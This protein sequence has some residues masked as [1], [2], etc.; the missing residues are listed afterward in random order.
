MKARDAIVMCLLALVP[1]QGAHAADYAP[2]EKLTLFHCGRCH[3][4]NQRNRYG[5]IGSTPS[6]AA[7]RTLADWEARFKTFWTLAPHPAFTQVA[8]M[9]EPFPADRPPPIHPVEL[10]LEQVDRIIG[11][12][13]TIAPKD[14]GAPI[15]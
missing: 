10:T 2:G 14:L 6:F 13:R 5:G 11:F 8:G 9:T 4:V 15:R 1:D 12:A 7:L 3:V